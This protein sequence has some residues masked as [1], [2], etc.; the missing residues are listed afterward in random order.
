M[1]KIFNGHSRITWEEMYYDGHLD[2]IEEYYDEETGKIIRLKVEDGWDSFE[3]YEE[4]EDLWS[5]ED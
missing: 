2:L 3:D 1:K 5:E 4:D